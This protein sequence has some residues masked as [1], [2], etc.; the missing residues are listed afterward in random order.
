MLNSTEKSLAVNR[1][2]PA[3]IQEE[4]VQR[5]PIVAQEA[6]HAETRCGSSNRRIRLDG[7]MGGGDREGSAGVLR[8]G[9]TI[10]ARV[11]SAAAWCTLLS[12]LRPELVIAPPA[13]REVVMPAVA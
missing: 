4:S 12:G 8:C 1:R 6:R 10:H 7:R 5:Y 11:S 9:T 3:G 13:A 2:P